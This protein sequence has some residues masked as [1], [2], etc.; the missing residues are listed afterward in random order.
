MKGLHLRARNSPIQMLIRPAKT[1]N[2]ND[3]ISLCSNLLGHIIKEIYGKSTIP[4]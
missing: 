2:L 1:L 3:I 4:D